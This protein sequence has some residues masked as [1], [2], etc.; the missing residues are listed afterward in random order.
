MQR[1]MSK[2]GHI[3]ALNMF[4]LGVVGGYIWRAFENTKARPIAVL[5]K[6]HIFD[7]N[8]DANP[9]SKDHNRH[10]VNIHD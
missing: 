7:G 3:G 8:P 6:Q 5:A 9:I 1:G 2:Q 4:A 10:N